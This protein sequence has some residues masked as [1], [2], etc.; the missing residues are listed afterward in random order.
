MA[1]AK[2]MEYQIKRVWDYLTKKEK[3]VNVLRKRLIKLTVDLNTRKTVGSKLQNMCQVCC[4]VKADCAELGGE[5]E[6]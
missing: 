4:D 6:C 3:E 5:G 2:Q 1:S